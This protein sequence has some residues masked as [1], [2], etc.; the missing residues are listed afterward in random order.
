LIGLLAIVVILVGYRE[1]IKAA[2]AT[3]PLHP[4]PQVLQRGRDLFAR[5]CVVCHG[6]GGRGD[7]PAAVALGQVPDDLS[8]IAPPPIFPDGVVAYRIKNGGD[9]MPAWKAVLSD[10]EV[11]CLIVYIRSLRRADASIPARVANL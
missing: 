4:S 10:D 5:Y 3:N 8:S 11:W 1:L 7:G 6:V 9:G 2:F